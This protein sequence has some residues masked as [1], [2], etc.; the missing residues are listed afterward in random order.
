MNLGNEFPQIQS[1]LHRRP[2]R[3]LFPTTIISFVDDNVRKFGIVQCNDSTAIF[4]YDILDF[5]ESIECQNSEVP[6]FS[7]LL[8]TM[9][10]SAPRVLTLTPSRSFQHSEGCPSRS[11]YRPG[12]EWNTLRPYNET[13]RCRNILS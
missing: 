3:K 9:S 6:S 7:E 10:K 2:F 13:Y 8:L 4:R 11:T 1:H 12:N 5:P